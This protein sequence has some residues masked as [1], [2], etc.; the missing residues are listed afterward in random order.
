MNPQ[1]VLQKD[2]NK[3]PSSRCSIQRTT[4][5]ILPLSNISSH[6]TAKLLHYPEHSIS[7]SIIHHHPQQTS[8]GLD[9]EG[10]LEEEDDGS[11]LRGRGRR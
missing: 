1:F 9:T 7:Q 6:H 2:C 8:L 11:V 4:T 10:G 5:L 3:H